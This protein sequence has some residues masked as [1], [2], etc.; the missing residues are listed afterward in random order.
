MSERFDYEK[1]YWVNTE[2]RVRVRSVVV[3]PDC[4]TKYRNDIPD[5]CVVCG[6]SFQ[7]IM[8]FINYKERKGDR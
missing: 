7:D 3:C 8:L 1:G 4:G 2:D 6:H 5:G